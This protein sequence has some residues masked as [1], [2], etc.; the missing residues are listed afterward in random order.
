MAWAI[1]TVYYHLCKKE[2]T[3]IDKKGVSIMP[4]LMR[5]A[6]N[7]KWSELNPLLEKSELFELI[8]DVI[9][10]RQEKAEEFTRVHSLGGATGFSNIVV[11]RDKLD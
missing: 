10:D 2:F 4:R 5:L 1:A 8:K 11:N 6:E 3:L 9:N 7:E